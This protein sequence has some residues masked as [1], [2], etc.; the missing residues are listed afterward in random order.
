MQKL[1]AHDLHRAGMCPATDVASPG[2]MVNGPDY[3]PGNCP[4]SLFLRDLNMK[5]PTCGAAGLTLD[6]RDLVYMHHGQR[7]VIPDVTAEFCA[8][9]DESITDLPETDR[10][11]RAMRCFTTQAEVANP[12]R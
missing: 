5:C 12:T 3:E 9:C 10:V 11:M 8:A 4:A 7:V 1:A 2:A 6:T